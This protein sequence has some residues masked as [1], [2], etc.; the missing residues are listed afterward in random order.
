MSSE[1]IH[2]E[3]QLLLQIAH[4]DRDAFRILYGAYFSKVQQYVALFEP[5]RISQDELTQ[6]VFVRVWEKRARLAGVESFKGYLFLVTRNVVF[7]FIRALKVR[8]RVQQLDDSVQVASNELEHELLFKQYYRIAIEAMDKLPPGRRKI[9]K[10]SIDDGF[11][12]DEIAGELNITRA[13]VK[14]QL[15]AATAFVRQYLKDH[16]EITLLLFVFLSLFEL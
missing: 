14:K 15:Y 10:M 1:G 6:D 3:K 5:S 4:G 8:Q 16:G 9:L 13:G 12:L 7:N 2:N 11:S